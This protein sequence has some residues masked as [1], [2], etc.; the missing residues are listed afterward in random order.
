MKFLV[1]GC[2]SI[3][4]RHIKNLKFLGYDDI[5]AYRTS[6]KNK[7]LIENKLKVRTFYD[8]EDALDECP[9]VVLVTNP[10]SLHIPTALRAIEND[11]HLFIEKPLSHS[12]NNV[13]KLLKKCRKGNKKIIIGNN[14][15]FNPCLK[16]IKSLVDNG[17]IGNVVSIRSQ[18]GQYLPDW[19]AWEDY[20]EGYYG[21]KDLGG[22]PI[23]TLIHELD[24][25][26]W[27]LGDVSS[28]FCFSDKLT[29]LEITTDDIAE[30]LMKF[31]NNAIGEVH[32]DYIQRYPTRSCH[33]IGDKGT[34]FWDD[35]KN[36]VNFF[37]IKNKKWIKYKLPK[38]YD[39]N[40]MYINEMKNVIKSINNEEKPMSNGEEG[41]KVLKIALATMESSKKNKVIRL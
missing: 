2:G 21:R 29:D 3:G 23:L 34:I 27:F 32:M 20:R 10:T 5:I 13:D 35:T 19:H 26:Y 38:S 17:E 40:Q 37:T 8:Y 14:L 9:D 33:I 22:G 36:E 12:L 4:I 39:K 31:K 11:C 15:R 25:P 16:Y 7:E 28:V 24:Y 6:K 18:V 41:K 30:I 1:V